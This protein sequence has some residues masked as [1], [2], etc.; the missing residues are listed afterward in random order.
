M[1]AEIQALLQGLKLCVVRKFEKVLVQTDYLVL[2]QHYN[3][4]HAVPWRNRETFAHI[5][6]LAWMLHSVQLFMFFGS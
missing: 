1:E 2:S 5:S 6:Y 4:A 3:G